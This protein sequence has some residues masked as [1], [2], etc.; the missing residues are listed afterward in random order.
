MAVGNKGWGGS[1][2]P[3]A[4]VSKEGGRGNWFN[5]GD[6]ANVASSAGD[7]ARGAE[8]DAGGS[9][10]AVS[11]GSNE[12]RPD[13]SFVVPPGLHGSDRAPPKTKGVTLKPPPQRVPKAVSKDT[14]LSLAQQSEQAMMNADP[15][16]LAVLEQSRALTTLVA[17]LQQGDPLID[18]PLS[19]SG[20]SSRGAQGWERLQ[21]ELADRTG[22]FFLQL[23]QNAYRRMYPASQLPATIEEMAS[24]G[25]SM[26]QYLERY[27][28]YGQSR[29]LG[30][31]QYGMSFVMDAAM[32][33]D[34]DGV[35]E[36]MALMTVAIEQT[37]MD[38]GRWERG[39]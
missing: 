19:S 34:M 18:A 12:A 16:A 7:D 1:E 35:R 29:D 38:G 9:Q 17:H 21:K 2:A 4:Y 33:N 39:Y 14:D 20:T 24:T 8:E 6:D 15:V 10:L 32:N 5:G 36:H 31:V 3:K 30:I 25:F 27:G 26:S 13:T 11:S 37:V 23:L 22:G 28:G